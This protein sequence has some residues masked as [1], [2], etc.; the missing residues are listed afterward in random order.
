MSSATDAHPAGSVDADSVDVLRSNLR[1]EL[2]G[3]SGAGY[4]EARA[5]WN[6]MIDKRPALIARCAGVADDA[7]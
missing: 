6:G 7:L 5:V 3:R 2:I 4:D 1:G